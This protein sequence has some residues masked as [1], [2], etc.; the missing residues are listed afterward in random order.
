MKGIFQVTDAGLCC[1]AGSFHVDPWKPAERAVIT[2]AHADHART[3]SKSYLTTRDGE[4]ILRGRLGDSASIQA[5][6]YG[7]SL[8]F[9]GVRVSLHPAG[10][11]LG[12]AQI[13]AEYGGEVWVVS[14][15]YKVAPDPTCAPFEP[16][17]CDT[18][19]TESTFG[20]P[21]YRWPNQQSV[22]EQ[23]NAWWTANREAGIASVLY[24]YSLGK[25][26]RLLA[27]IDASIG[28]VFVHGAV[29]KVNRGYEASG[30]PLPPTR[31]ALEAEKQELPG[32]LIVAPPATQGT[33][34]QRRFGDFSDGFAS[35]WMS[36]RGARRRLAVDRGFV[37]SD[38][39]DWPELLGAI[40]DTG[41]S[42]VLVTHG[43]QEP[44]VRYLR[45]SGLEA[46][47]L[48]TQFEGE[49]DGE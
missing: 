6:E 3:G 8:D 21:I 12:S 41:A 31:P 15:D 32:A 11:V 35:G 30:I 13:R 10:H 16:V 22:F 25:A 20:L 24:G 44:L 29:E 45:E 46:E 47:S 34:W 38:H 1:E 43:V 37:L 33:P 26:Q 36:L 5:V 42:R 18:F 40:R 7:E 9:D 28:P 48:E 19:I 14:G 17:R 39:A 27:G 4:H 23:V 2:H 49:E